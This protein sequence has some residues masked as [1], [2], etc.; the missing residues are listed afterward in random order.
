MT[1]AL[2]R[3]R[4]KRPSPTGVTME[5]TVHLQTTLICSLDPCWAF[6]ITAWGPDLDSSSSFLLFLPRKAGLVPVHGS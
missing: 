5:D 6:Q 4:K 1:S 3:C 2:G